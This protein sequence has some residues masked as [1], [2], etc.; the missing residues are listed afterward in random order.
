MPGQSGER[1]FTSQV[2]DVDWSPARQANLPSTRL[3]VRGS[4]KIKRSQRPTTKR[5]P[6]RVHHKLRTMPPKRGSGR[7]RGGLSRGGSLAQSTSAHDAGA[8][9]NESGAATTAASNSQND[10]MDVDP[11]LSPAT[12][13]TETPAPTPNR[14]PLAPLPPPIAAPGGTTTA[15]KVSKF[16]PKNIRRDPKE[17]ARLEQEERERLAKLNSEQSRAR[18]GTFRRGGRGDAMGRGKVIPTAV[19]SG[20]FAEAPETGKPYLERERKAGANVY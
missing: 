19:A 11:S 6:R 15:K 8:Q 4:Q 10:L 18:R 2:S 3:R 9:L 7:G 5:Q 13:P 16:R 14:A 20:P 1:E 12:Q 17:L